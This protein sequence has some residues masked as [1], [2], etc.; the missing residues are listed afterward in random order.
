VSVIKKIAF[1]LL[2]LGGTV[3]A[4]L[5]TDLRPALKHIP[6]VGSRPLTTGSFTQPWCVDQ[7]DTQA[8]WDAEFS[9]MQSAGIDLWIYQ[10]TGDSVKRTTIYPTTIAGWQQSS[11][12]DQVEMALS[13]ARRY[14]IKVYMGL[15]FSDQ[16]WGKEGS[17]RDWLM[18]EA[19]AMNSVADELYAN[20]F[21][22]YPETFAG[23]YI[24]WEM[25][26]VAGYNTL[27]SHKRNMIEALEAVSGHLESL[28]QNL[29][30][31]IAPFFN[32]K[33]GVGPRRWQYFW[34]DV[35]RKTSV[36]IL[37]LQDGV[38]VNHATVEQLPEWFQAVCD[39]AHA[40]GKQCWSDLE[41]FSET[42]PNIFVPAPTERVIAQHQ[43]V[44]PYVD[45]II[46]FSF[47][48]YMS[49]AYGVDE[50]YLAGYQAYRNSVR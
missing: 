48:S 37:M 16:W 23:W 29:P 25:D 3:S 21:S 6:S 13:T 44:A 45:R 39:A 7:Y 24:N 1:I 18:A 19:K 8:A 11:A 47:I 38:G 49:P 32:S 20:Y 46:T 34:L 42:E 35:L 9:A 14:G 17:D 27:P 5:L 26:N 50:K 12:Y 31:G 40:A 22:R 36:D 2:V 28:N 33:F 41:N 43:A 15:A 30:S 10:W 4:F